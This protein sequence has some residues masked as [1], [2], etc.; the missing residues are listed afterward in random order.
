VCPF[1]VLQTVL[2]NS[3]RNICCGTV[4]FSP[5]CMFYLSSYRVR[6]IFL[7]AFYK[8]F[9]TCRLYLAALYRSYLAE[10]RTATGSVE[11]STAEIGPLDCSNLLFLAD[12]TTTTR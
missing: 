11:T 10:Q 3:D 4:K 12:S 9:Y 7:C 5:P 6:Y 1:Q 8:V 2:S